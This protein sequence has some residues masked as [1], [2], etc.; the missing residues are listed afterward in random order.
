MSAASGAFEQSISDADNLIAHFNSLNTK[1][2]PPELE[3]LKRAGPIESAF[4]YNRTPQAR[5]M[6][7]T[8]C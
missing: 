1:P 5:M 7:S 4:S 3:V 2:P 8:V 6:P